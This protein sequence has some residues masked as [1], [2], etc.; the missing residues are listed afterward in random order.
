MPMEHD[1]IYLIDLWHLLHRQWRWFVAVLAAVVAAAVLF[2]QLAHPRWEAVAWIRPGQLGAVPAGEDP[3]IEPFQRAIER[4]QTRPF[5]DA[6]L[7]DLG[8]S[9]RS[10]EAQLYRQ[11][12]DLEP[13]PYAGLLKLT[14]RGYSPEQARRFVQATYVH[15]RQLHEGLMAEPLR[16]AEARLQQTQA[17]LDE[18]TAERTRLLQVLAAAPAQGVGGRDRQDLLM[19]TM[20]LAGSSR[21]VRGLQQAVSDLKARLTASYSYE[22]SLAWPIYAPERP[23]Y[24]NRALIVAGGV[25]L[26]LGLGL[27]VAV[28]RDARRRVAAR[29]ASTAPVASGTHHPSPGM[30]ARSS[31]AGA[32]ASEDRHEP[33]LP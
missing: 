28:A 12:F 18:A 29:A 21:E 31:A 27:M 20:V 6:V 30:P 4:M 14:L 11:S 7:R 1:E 3:R 2:A 5:Q 33:S 16:L 13:S 22:T 23:V 25:V 17:Q 8:V 24:P 32:V 26:G 9:S 19:A 10:R 15:L